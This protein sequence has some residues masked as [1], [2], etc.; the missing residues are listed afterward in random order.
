MAQKYS[1][2]QVLIGLIIAITFSLMLLLVAGDSQKN[3]QIVQAEDNSFTTKNAPFIATFASVDDPQKIS[4]KKENSAISFKIP[5]KSVKW[6]KKGDKLEAEAENGKTYS[7]TLLKT[8][9][10]TATGL[11]EEIVL[12]KPIE[13]NV[14]AFDID[15]SLLKAK[16]ENNLWH[17]YNSEGKALFYIPKPFMEDANGER[18]EN[19][20][21]DITQDKLKITADKEWLLST[22]RKYPVTIDPTFKLTILT[23]HSHPQSGDNWVVDF[24]THGKADLKIIPDDQATIED[25]DFVSLKCGSKKMNPEILQNDVISYKNWECNQ[26]A[27]VTHLVNTADPHTL[28]FDFGG[29]INYAYNAP[30]STTY[31]FTG[32][33]QSTN[34][35]YAY[36][37]YGATV[38]SNQDDTG[39]SEASN[40]DYDNI[41]AD[42]GNRWV[43]EEATSDGDYDSQLYKFYIDETESTV[44]QLDLKWNGYGETETGY[45]TYFYIWDYNSSNWE[46]LDS[47][48]FTAATDADLTGTIDSSVGNYIDIEGEVTLMAK[49]E[50]VVP[51][52][53]FTDCTCAGTSYETVNCSNGDTIYVDCN[54]DKC[55]APTPSGLYSYDDAMDYCDNLDHG[56]ISNWVLPDKD[57][58]ANLCNS[59]SCSSYCFGGD[60]YDGGYLSSDINGLQ[61]N[62]VFFDGCIEYTQTDPYFIRC[63]K[64]SNSLYTDYVEL[65]VTYTKDSG[66]TCEADSDCTSGNCVDGYCCDT[67]CDGICEACDISGSE[68]TCTNIAEDTD[69]D[70]ECDL[71]CANGCA[72]QT[73]DCNGSG[74]CKK[75]YC[76]EGQACSS[77][78]CGTGNYC[79]SGNQAYCS[80]EGAGC[81]NDGGFDYVC[82][83]QCDA[84]GNCTYSANCS[85]PDEVPNKV[86][87]SGGVGLEN[88]G[89]DY[90]MP[91]PCADTT[92]DNCFCD[93]TGYCEITASGDTVYVDCNADKCW[94]PTASSTYTWSSNY[95]EGN[96]VGQGSDYE[97]CHYCDT[98]SYGGKDDWFLPGRDTLGDL[99]DSGAC[100]GTC[101]GG[102]GFSERY[103]CSQDW[104][105]I[106]AGV[107]DFS[108]CLRQTDDK[109]NDN[110][111]RCVR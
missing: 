36:E 101:F 82:Q 9:K 69:P 96:C 87:F 44:S 27:T 81:Y 47:N 108:G 80:C 30:G 72:D 66:E 16:K 97:A 40:T 26:T 77:G 25:I 17:F 52:P 8:E 95:S 88:V 6:A 92:I 37:D 24:E 86:G 49:T 56:G 21:I 67:A 4:F 42:D 15:F 35:Y 58:L 91:E 109:H 41:E 59:D 75:T 103:W 14:F 110:Y 100:E 61:I 98:L 19:I 2:K 11:K 12:K 71:S 48:D 46:Q 89:L 99:C 7:Y 60:G 68:G 34:D 18:S 84:S 70:N 62:T 102:D 111:V 39:T 107:V 94:T 22:D 55:W 43:T 74:A 54:A 64:V 85:T 83:G 10:G 38:F 93:G 90:D 79:N 32:V 28:K 23:V 29:E 5:D 53:E 33:T 57:T 31:T 106:E 65:K 76:A 63:V 1:A 51:C 105:L 104:D 13:Q 20:K 78:S 45:S 3:A 73:G 50:K